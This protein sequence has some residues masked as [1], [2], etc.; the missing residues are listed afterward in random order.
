MKLATILAKAGRRCLER[1]PVPAAFVTAL[2]GYSIFN[3]L[4]EITPDRLTGAIYYF[5]SV[6]FV[7]SLTLALWN[8]EQE[9]MKKVRGIYIMSYIILT[10]DA[11][12]LYH[13]NFGTGG[14]GYETFLMH[15][16]AILALVLTVFFLSFHRERNDIPSWNFALRLV[17]YGVVCCLVGLVLWG[18]LCL[19]LSSMNWLFSIHIGW[20]WYS[21]AGVLV[22][23]YLPALLFLGR[24]PGGEKKHDREPLHSSFLAG[25]FRYLFLPLETL[26]LVVLFLYALQILVRWELP[27]GQVSWLVIAS[28]IGLI[29]IEFGLYPTRYADDR[30][31]DHAIARLLPLILTPLLLLMTV[32]IVRRFS[33][34]GITIARLYLATLNVWFYAVCL[35][36]F[37]SR[38]RRISWIPISFAALFLLTSALPL[39]Y[40]S[41][42][43]RTLMKEVERAL[44]QAGATDL[45]LDANRYDALMRTLPQEEQNSINAKLDYL[46]STFSAKTFEPLVTQQ[47]GGI[48]FKG[49]IQ[50]PGNLTVA[51]EGINLYGY[52]KNS[53]HLHIPEG[54]TELYLDVVGNDFIIDLRRDTFEVPVRPEQGNEISDTVIVSLRKLRALDKQ[55]DD[56]VPLPTKSSANL[57]YLQHFNVYGG[58]V[59]GDDDLIT[60]PK[61]NISGYMLT[62]GTKE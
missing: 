43:R 36:L 11:C 23:G 15:A 60:S 42:T 48:F 24:I 3:I 25:V 38:A 26:Y 22:A 51:L 59:T 27:D 7:L 50:R 39:N 2:A 19:L 16:S 57:F 6:G 8:E 28:M 49:Y 31:F 13:I 32:G 44:A 52:A 56:I 47:Q 35:G 21:I 33:D 41:L 29:G 17:T 1:F 46:E 10:A 61:L 20:K 45:P 62:R 12:Y 55:M 37:L 4:A 9:R 18:G 40:T 34:Y 30:P 14:Q 58:A 53:T 54:Y 5:L